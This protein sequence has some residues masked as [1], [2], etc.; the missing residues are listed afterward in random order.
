MIYKLNNNKN[1]AIYLF[2]VHKTVSK[3]GC[4][5]ITNCNQITIKLIGCNQITVIK[6]QTCSFTNCMH[7]NIL[8]TVLIYCYLYI[9]FYKL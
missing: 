1:M 8:L 9:G 2:T 4:N 5:Q 3:S 7:G 6:L